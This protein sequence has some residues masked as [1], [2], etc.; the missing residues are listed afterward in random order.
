MNLLIGV[1][2]GLVWND[3]EEEEED[4]ENG[5]KGETKMEENK[6]RMKMAILL[7]PLEK[8]QVTPP[9]LLKSVYKVKCQLFKL[10][11]MYQY[12]RYL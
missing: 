10:F 3:W 11:S 1:I 12:Y 4:E 5:R 7:S 9:A 2:F 6:Q 8:A